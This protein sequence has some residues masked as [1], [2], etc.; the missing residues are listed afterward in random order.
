MTE[1]TTKKLIDELRAVMADAEAL[2]GAGAGDLGDR[3]AQARSQVADSVAKAQ[4]GLEELESQLEARTKLLVEDATRFVRDNP[5]Q[6]VGIAAAVGVA[7]G[8]FLGRRR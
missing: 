1:A 8:V 6:S 7:L 3:A 2:I 4:A 5:W